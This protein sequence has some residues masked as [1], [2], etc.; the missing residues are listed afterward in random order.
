MKDTYTNQGQGVSNPTEAFY[1]APVLA[2]TQFAA[3]GPVVWAHLFS[4]PV[5]LAHIVRQGVQDQNN[6]DPLQP[7]VE[8]P[9]TLRPAQ[10]R[11][12]PKIRMSVAD[13]LR[14]LADRYVNN[15]DSVIGVVRLEPGPSGGFQVVIIVEVADLV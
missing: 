11:R 4:L 6:P 3:P 8:N 13:G 1:T 2:Q 7:A 15:P 14:R 10:S 12:D 5:Y 9:P